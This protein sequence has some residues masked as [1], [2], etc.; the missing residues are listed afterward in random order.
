M[1]T[2]RDLKPDPLQALPSKAAL[3]VTPSRK[4]NNFNVQPE[5]HKVAGHFAAIKDISVD[6]GDYGILGESYVGTHGYED[7]ERLLK[8]PIHD[9]GV[10]PGLDGADH[11]LQ[12]SKAMSD[13]DADTA[14]NDDGKDGTPKDYD[15]EYGEETPPDDGTDAHPDAQPDELN[16]REAKERYTFTVRGRY[17]GGDNNEQAVADAAKEFAKDNPGEEV[18]MYDR[19]KLIATLTSDGK[20]IDIDDSIQ[21]ATG[22]EAYW[23]SS[24]LGKEYPDPK[25]KEAFFT[26]FKSG[27]PKKNP[28]NKKSTEYYAY[29]MGVAYKIHHREK[30]Y[31][32]IPERVTSEEAMG[33]VMNGANV[34]EVLDVGFIREATFNCH[35]NEGMGETFPMSEKELHF[36]GYDF[37]AGPKGTKIHRKMVDLTKEGDYG[38]DPL[39]GGKFKMVPSGDVVDTAEM[40]RR[41]KK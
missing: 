7:D 6:P 17:Q 28:H 12:V 38:A 37:T 22:I 18:K 30:K 10:E 16:V 34:N 20:T 13:K 24:K 5:L 31:K 35:Y 21:E 40:R 15:G 11:D 29:G 19:K 32:E 9:L 36:A 23:R 41:L 3:G 27:D 4:E 26:G 8:A 39:G 25:V 33:A 2:N 14:Y 1:D